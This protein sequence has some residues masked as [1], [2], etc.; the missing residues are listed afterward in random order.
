MRA[1]VVHDTRAERF[2]KV[3]VSVQGDFGGLL[4]IDIC[5]SSHAGKTEQFDRIRHLSR[6]IF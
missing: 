6:I 4:K 2:N 1:R 3:N 5:V